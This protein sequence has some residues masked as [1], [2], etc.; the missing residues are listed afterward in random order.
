MPH[1]H[2]LFY[3]PAAIRTRDLQ[4]RRLTLYPAELRVHRNFLTIHQEST[5]LNKLI[6]DSWPA[7]S[8]RPKI[9]R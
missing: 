9:I 3:T 2:P 8:L 1:R 7:Y 4:L 5:I 6:V